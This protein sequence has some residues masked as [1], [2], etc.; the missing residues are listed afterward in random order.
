M[1]LLYLLYFGG[2]GLFDIVSGNTDNVWETLG[3][4]AASIAG[5]VL[6]YIY[7]YRP[8]KGK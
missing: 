7:I 2:K 3:Y 6:Y 1:I 4:A 8:F 5:A